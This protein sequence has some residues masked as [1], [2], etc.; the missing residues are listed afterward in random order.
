[1]IGYSKA[2]VSLFSK[3]LSRKLALFVRDIHVEVVFRRKLGN[4]DN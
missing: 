2:I 3:V 1:M 4:G